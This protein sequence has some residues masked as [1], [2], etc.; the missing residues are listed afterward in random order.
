VLSTSFTLSRLRFSGRK[1]FMNLLLVLGMFPGFMSMIAVYYILKGLGLSQSL[2]ALILVYGGGASLGYYV[3]KGFFDTIPKSLDEAARIDG[4][5]QWQVFT[6]IIMP[7]SKPI[8]IYTI[9]TSFMTPWADFIFPRVIMGDNYD[10]YTIAL[11]LYTM[12]E[13][14]NI[15][16]WYTRFA[17]GAVLVSIPI[18]VLFM[19]MQK[20]YVEGI[21][22]AVKG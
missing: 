7:V 4:A 16:T 8:V 3:S 20:Y 5:T 19:C 6:K 2:A 15:E 9:L 11:G 13:R 12:L 1:M 22:G 21:S 18:T 14:A 17:A 10:N